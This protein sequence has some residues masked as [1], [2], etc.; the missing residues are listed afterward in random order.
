MVLLVLSTS[1]LGVF[2]T[3]NRYSYYY[4]KLNTVNKNYIKSEHINLMEEGYY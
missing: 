2:L 4:V 3:L 1:V